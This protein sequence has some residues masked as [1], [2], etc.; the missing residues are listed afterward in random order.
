MPP[1]KAARSLVSH[2]CASRL[3]AK[4]LPATYARP[5]LRTA[6]HLPDSNLRM[7]T[8][9]PDEARPPHRPAGSAGSRA[10]AA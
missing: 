2:A 4:V 9:L 1:A 10:T 8:P 7:L 6:N 5:D 3:V